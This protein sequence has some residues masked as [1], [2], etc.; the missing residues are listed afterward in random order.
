MRYTFLA[1]ATALS[2]A[3]PATGL[4][5]N[6]IPPDELVMPCERPV[7]VDDITRLVVPMTPFRGVNLIFPFELDDDATT[8]SLSS[9]LV[10]DFTTAQGRRMV[11][12]HFAKF[13]DQWGEVADFTIATGDY[14]FSITLKADP[15]IKNHCTNIVFEFTEEQLKAIREGER[16]EHLA[17][18][19]A[20]YEKKL[21]ALDDQASNKALELV[22][23][24][25]KGQ[26]SSSGIH[27][28]NGLVLSNGDEI[29]IYVE[30]LQGWGKFSVLTAEVTN[31]S[32]VNPLYIKKVTIG[33]L[34]DKGRKTPIAGHAEIPPRLD[35]DNVVPLTFTTTKNIPKTNAFLE[36]ETDRGTVEVKW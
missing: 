6:N 34:D 4:A 23:S 25:A 30:E 19:D 28:T 2:M 5:V 33:R 9:N 12:I 3:T 22:G 32:R 8:Y 20:E 21:A 16:K 13:Q 31:D 24:L 29:E 1:I 36:L 11:P 7:P 17:R 35:L 10:W 15:S 26:S 27:E 14:I 18:L